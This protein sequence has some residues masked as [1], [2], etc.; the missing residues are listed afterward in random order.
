MTQLQTPEPTTNQWWGRHQIALRRTSYWQVGPL[1]LWIQHLPHQWR[2]AWEHTDDWL[3]P[4][5]RAMPEL[6]NENPPDGIF[7]S[8]F[9]FRESGAEIYFSPTLANRPVVTKLETP[10]QVLSGEDVMLYV[11]TPLW[12]KFE[13]CDPP[14]ALRDIA[15]FRLSDTW[16]GPVAV[17]GGELCYASRIPAVLKL[18]DVPFRPHCAI[19]AVHLRNLGA[20]PLRL[21]RLNL[22]MPR[23]SLFYSA[24]SGFWTDMIT[25]E[26]KDEDSELASIKLEQQPP[27]EAAPTQFV[28]SARI[29]GG[30]PNMVFRAFSALF[31][32]KG[33]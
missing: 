24:Q 9:A 19:T 25:L 8:R 1:H 28:S 15:C 13:I 7:E 30:E 23:L 6:E 4:T 22:P 14:K 32:D 10:I 26:R 11:S 5:M 16:F 17:P 27:P 21:E 20:T 2:L 31:R 18:E 29:G 3:E 12:V 33:E